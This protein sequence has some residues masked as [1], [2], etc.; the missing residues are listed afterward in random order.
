M[1]S[2][3]GEKHTCLL[4]A[5]KAQPRG[6]SFLW[7]WGWPLWSSLPCSFRAVPWPFLTWLG[8]DLTF[9]YGLE[10]GGEVFYLHFSEQ[11]APLTWKP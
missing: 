9:G 10:G 3:N 1:S 5:Q 11:S 4:G 8:L 6:G 7:D 2:G